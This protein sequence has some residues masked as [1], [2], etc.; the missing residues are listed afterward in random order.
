MVLHFVRGLIELTSG[1]RETRRTLLDWRREELPGKEE[2]R[3][4]NVEVRGQQ[5][6]Y[7]P[8]STL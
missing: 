5:D 3:M 7:L 1:Q 8:R 4:K 2:G 6:A